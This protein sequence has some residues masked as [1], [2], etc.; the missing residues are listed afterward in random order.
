MLLRLRTV[1]EAYRNPPRLILTA[2]AGVA[3]AWKAIHQIWGRSMAGIACWILVLFPESVLLGSSQM[4]EPF[5]ITF[6]AMLFWG[7][8]DWQSSRR[9]QAWAWIAGSLAGM[10]LISPGVAVLAMIGLGGWAWL[11]SRERRISWLPVLI[12]LAVM[13]VGLTLLGFG[14]AR[15][16]LSGASPYALL[17]NWL[18]VTAKWDA[19]VLA[20]NS[21]WIERVFE[22]LPQP[23]HFP[24]SRPTARA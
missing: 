20:R 16:A 9:R 18:P 10:L 19:Y 8:V 13:V 23:L 21:G 5:L 1:F 14:L 3:L 6:V 12:V 11:R 22:E 15:G 24:R 17:V 7:L 2:A 4:R